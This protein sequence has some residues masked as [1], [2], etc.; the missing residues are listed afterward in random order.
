M[1]GWGINMDGSGDVGMGNGEWA[2]GE[3]ISAY[4]CLPLR[5]EPQRA[6]PI[7]SYI[8]MNHP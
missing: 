6:V 2:D 1:G 4:I 3:G 5:L 8:N 7:G